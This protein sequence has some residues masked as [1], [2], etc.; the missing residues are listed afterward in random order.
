MHDYLHFLRIPIYGLYYIENLDISNYIEA[1]ALLFKRDYSFEKRKNIYESLEWAIFNPN[2]DFRSI[3]THKD[4]P[5]SN[6]EIFQ[7]LQNLYLFMKKYKLDN[8]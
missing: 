2:Y 4:L 8:Q 6:V 3:S 7:Y 1:D 5:Y